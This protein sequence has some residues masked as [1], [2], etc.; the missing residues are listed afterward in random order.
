MTYGLV[1]DFLL[2]NPLRIKEEQVKDYLFDV[3]ELHRNRTPYWERTL[4]DIDLNALFDSRKLSKVVENLLNTGMFVEENYLRSNWLEFFPRDY[5]G[6]VRFYQSSGTTRERAIGHWDRNY[7][8]YLVAYLK[9]SLDELYDFEGLYGDEKM[10]AIAHGPYG[11][12]QDEISELVWRYS[13]YLYFIG[14]ETDGLKKVL[15]RE[16]VEAVLRILDPLVRYTSRVMK[17]D[18]INLVRSAPPLMNIFEPYAEEIRAIILSGVGIDESLFRSLSEKFPNSTL[19]PLYGYYLFGDLIGLQ[20]GSKFVYYPNWPFTIIYPV[21]KREDG[22]R[23]LPPGKR[24]NLALVVAR[25]EVLMIKVED[26]TVER[27]KGNGPFRCD[28]F[29]NPKRSVR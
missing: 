20:R 5:H 22:Y 8:D 18:R 3:I 11:W 24:G 28:G 13:G 25:P 15:A 4:R 1:P 10:R 26:E 27:V 6:K 14:M 17:A 7:V 19:V 16:G 29:A 2:E 12:Y 21:E 23:V 9:A